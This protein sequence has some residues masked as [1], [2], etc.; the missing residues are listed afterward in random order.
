MINRPFSLGVLRVFPLLLISVLMIGFENFK[1]VS[2]NVR[3]ALH[4]N[5]KLAIRDIVRHKQPDVVILIETKCQFARARFFW[6]SLGFNP[7]FIQEARG[8]SGGIWVL[9]NNRSNVN[10]RVVDNHEQ[11]V[12]FELWREN[13][14]WVC[15][16]IYASPIPVNREILWRHLVHLRSF[17]LAPWML[18]GDFNEILYPSEVRGGEFLHNRAAQFA[19]ILESCQL[20]ALRAVQRRFT[21]FR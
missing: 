7:I 16:A 13:V 18:L 3:G 8:F 6:N 15:S 21:W 11:V 1:I 5:G 12:T 9:L 4:E 17:L 2:W 19:S 20:Q 10:F 14:A